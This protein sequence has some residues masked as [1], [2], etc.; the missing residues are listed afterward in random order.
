MVAHLLLLTFNDLAAIK[1]KTATKKTATKR[2][3]KDKKKFADCRASQLR[4]AVGE[5]K[6]D[7]EGY[8]MPGEPSVH[9]EG[10]SFR[11]V[12]KELEKKG[13]RMGRMP[14]EERRMKNT[15]LLVG[16]VKVPV[17]YSEGIEDTTHDYKAIRA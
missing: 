3:G 11:A 16:E 13:E 15:E 6:G 2:K 7:G 8:Q 4:S 12:R 10:R 17:G 1:K 14:K 9:I 5:S